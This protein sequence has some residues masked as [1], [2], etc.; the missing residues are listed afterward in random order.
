M[1][2]EQASHVIQQGRTPIPSSP[3]SLSVDTWSLSK[4]V[5]WYSKEGH[6]SHHR[7][8]HSVDTWSLN[9]SVTC[10]F[11]QT[12][13]NYCPPRDTGCGAGT[14]NSECVHCIAVSPRLWTMWTLCNVMSV[15]QCLIPLYISRRQNVIPIYIAQ[16]TAQDMCLLT[17]FTFSRWPLSRWTPT[18][19]RKRTTHAVYTRS[20]RQLLMSIR[21]Q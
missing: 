18:P 3:V 19:F 1:I 6:Q 10:A 12:C 21:K 15:E 16:W 14:G 5:T 2:S 11:F 9:T 7:P 20:N 13:C 8:F 17:I 4:P